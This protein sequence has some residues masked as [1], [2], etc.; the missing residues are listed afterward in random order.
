[1]TKLD[2]NYNFSFDGLYEYNLGYSDDEGDNRAT[3]DGHKFVYT[4]KET[5]ANGYNATIEGDGEEM[6]VRNGAAAVK[7][8]NRI[9]QEYVEITGNKFWDDRGDSSRRPDVT[10]NLY[11]SDT[12]GRDNELVDTYVIPNTKSTYEFGTPGRK[13]LPKY[14]IN[15]K[16]ISYRVEEAELKG[17]VSK[18]TGNDF[19]NT[20]S[21]IRVSKLEATNREE[22]PGAVLA[23][24]RKSDNK[25]IERWISGNESHYIEALDL[26]EVYT[27]VEISAPE[28]YVKAAPIDFQVGLDGVEQ[29]VEM[30][31]DPI[32][33]SVILTK[34]D[35]ST[36]EKLAGAEFEL[37]SQ[38]GKLQHVTGNTGDYTFAKDGIGI[39]TLAVNSD[40]ELKIAEIPYGSYYFKETK[41]PAGYELK[42]GTVAFTISEQGMEAD[43]SFTDARKLGSVTLTKVSEDGNKALSGAVFELYSKTPRSSGQAAASTVFSDAYYRYGTYT[44]DSSGRITVSD[45]PWDDYFFVETEA[46]EGYEIARDISGDSIAYTFTV[47]A[48]NVGPSTISLGNITNPEKEKESGVAGVREPIAEKVSGVLGVRSAPKKGVL[49][50]RTGPATGDASTIALWLALLIACVGTIVWLISSRKKKDEV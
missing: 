36:R 9:R 13:Q 41:A 24:V 18:Q 10:V 23:I 11:A 31:D 5:G 4:I 50:A 30:F 39:T 42:S 40:G 7:I 46:P 26:G 6:S 19:T 21:R 45:L 28:G 38:D 2:A 3:A 12:A 15:G 35:E 17:Y 16:V 37:Y 22:L 14:D 44:T 27:L 20:P 25:E 34:L 33:G 32:L 49:G 43:V 1:E 8:T 29:K 48:D 47:G